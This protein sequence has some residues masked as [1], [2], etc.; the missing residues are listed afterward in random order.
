MIRRPP[1]STLFPYTTLFRSDTKVDQPETQL[2]LDRD[3]AASMGL[4][5]AD[6]GAD[7]S[8]LVGG[9]FVN[10]FNFARR[11][12]KVI[13]QLKRVERLNASQLE[14]TY[15]KGPN[16]QL[17]PLSTFAR[18]ETHTEPSSLNRFQQLNAVKIQGMS[19]L[20]L[21]QALTLLETQAAEILPK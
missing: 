1:R 21:D 8:A 4:N 19:M 9:Y 6:V 12:Y 10:R 3:K 13:P 20:P 7:L 5:M 14:S 17:V 16:G 2:V 15:V 18:L 11:S